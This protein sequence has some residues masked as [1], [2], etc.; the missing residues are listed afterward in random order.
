M[1]IDKLV[2]QCK[3]K[4]T[5]HRTAKTILT[6]KRVPGLTLYLLLLYT[7]FK[8]LW[9]WHED[10]HVDQQNGLWNPKISTYL[11]PGV[12]DKIIQQREWS[13]Q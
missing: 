10:R 8:T 9:Y 4:G 2:L 7:V 3:W 12:F 11:W 13:L 6:K 1:G 5:S